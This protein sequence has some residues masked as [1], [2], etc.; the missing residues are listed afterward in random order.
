MKRLLSLTTALLMVLTLTAFL[1]KGA[2]TAAALIDKVEITM[3][4]PDQ[5]DTASENSSE[6]ITSVTDDITVSNIRWINDPESHSYMEPGDSFVLGHTYY[7]VVYFSNYQYSMSTDTAVTIN[8]KKAEYSPYDSSGSYWGFTYEFTVGQAAKKVNITITPIVAGKNPDF[9]ASTDIDGIIPSISASMGGLEYNKITYYDG[10]N[11]LEEGDKFVA[12]KEYTVVADLYCL[13]DSY[14][15]KDTVVYI[16]DVKAETTAE[17]FD[18]DVV[19]TAKFTATEPEYIDR[20]DIT[21]TQPKAGEKPDRKI[22]SIT[23]EDQISVLI[24]IIDPNTGEIIDSES[25]SF[26]WFEHIDGGAGYEVTG[27]FEAD[28]TYT[29][30]LQILCASRCYMDDKSKVYVNGVLAKPS[31]YSDYNENIFYSADFSL[32]SYALGDVNADGKID[33]E[34][35]VMVINNVNGVTPLT[36]DQIKCADIDGNKTID[37]ED[38]VAIIS[39]VNGINPIA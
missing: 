4:M 34:D 37:I 12:G 27:T 33:I 20:I 17:R 7:A 29:A 35:A 36:D 26:I 18:C 11:V 9:F 23:P 30:E 3:K 22:K 32:K 19:Y 25:D 13:S 5:F 16:D 15:T 39:H 10:E 31:E 14:L 38:A 8:G 21:V 1:P 2:L 28:H 6:W 24:P